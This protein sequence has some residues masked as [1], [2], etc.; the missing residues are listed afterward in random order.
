MPITAAA[1]GR[2]VAADDERPPRST[3]RVLSYQ[4]IANNEAETVDLRQRRPPAVR[5][6]RHRRHG[7]RALRQ[8]Q[9][10]RNGGLPGLDPAPATCRPTCRQG[11]PGR[12]GRLAPTKAGRC[13][14]TSTTSPP[15]PTWRSPPAIRRRPR[16]RQ[17]HQGP[18]QHRRGQRHRRRPRVTS[19][20]RSSRTASS[21][22]RSTPSSARAS[23]TSAR[24]AT[25]RTRAISPPSA[26]RH[27]TTVGS[28]GTG[29]YH[30]LRRHRRDQPPAADHGQRRRRPQLIFQFDQPFK[31]QQPAG[32][33]NVVTSQVNFYVLD[34]GTATIVGLGHQRQHR[35]PGAAPDRDGPDHRQ[36]LRG[37]SRWSTGPTPAT[38]SSSSSASRHRPDRL[39]AVRLGGRARPIPTRTATTP[40]PNTIGVGATPWWAPAP[41]LGQNPLQVRAVQL[42]R[43]VDHRPQPRRLA[44]VDPADGPESRRSRHPTAATRRSSAGL[45]RSTPATRRSRASRRPPTNLSQNLPSFFGTSSATPNAAAVAALMKQKCPPLASPA[46]IKAGLIASAL[47]MNATAAGDVESPVGLRPDQRRQGHQRRRRPPGANRPIRPTA[48]PCR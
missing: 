36:L 41:Y 20:S 33:T 8:R 31:T 48:R 13:S 34:A 32:S 10:V 3:S 22:R 45:H 7:R 4:G 47:P 38:S 23:P 1:D 40:A 24:R 2:R 28:L 39:A 29:T 26:A 21:P 15:A 27:G 30:E 11:D 5:R 44:A 9:P 35:D 18:G 14:R 6:R 46:D 25:R 19:T 42:V 43:P 17:Q 37:R 16:L 12:P